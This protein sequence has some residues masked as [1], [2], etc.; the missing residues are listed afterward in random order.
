MAKTLGPRCRLCRREAVKLFLKGSRCLSP[1][2]AMVRKNYIPGRTGPKPK[3]T[4]LS[5]YG[6][7]LRE[8]Q[9]L[10][11]IYGILERQFRRYYK[12]ASRKSGVT[13]DILLQILESRLDNVVYRA[14]LAHSRA[15]ARQLVSHGLFLVNGK[16]VNLPS[17]LVREK[18]KIT[19]AKAAEKTQYF[20]EL[21]LPPKPPVAWL[22]LDPKTKEAIILRKPGRQDIDHSVDMALI[23]EYYSR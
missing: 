12:E 9:K 15:Q 18:D 17:Y 6:L 20:R 3:N 7:H 8:K 23:V 16:K 4:R 2:C 22:N 14:S 11:R 19:L 13:G 21:Q 1:K 10:R 5:E